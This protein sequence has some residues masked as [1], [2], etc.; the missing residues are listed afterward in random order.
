MVDMNAEV[1]ASLTT[2]AGTL[3]LAVATYASTRSANR[4]SRVAERSLLAGLQ[5]VLMHARLDDPPQK[6]GFSDN[7]WIRF[8]GPGGG[9]EAGDDAVY[10][11]FAVRNVGSG[12][13]VLQGWRPAIGRLIGGDQ[14][15]PDPSEF[16]RLTRDLYIAAG[17]LGFWQGV[18]RDPTESL[19][20]DYATA[21]KGREAVTIDLLYTDMHGGQRTVTRFSLMPA[22][23]DRWLSTVGRH[24]PIDGVNPR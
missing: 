7:H 17:D 15:P 22:G 12:I 9:F 14:H 21:A 13:A 18:F 8:E 4:A 2:A 24:W 1:I 16:R 11:A 5:P 23:G 19:Y 20:D 3:V 6:V 10:L